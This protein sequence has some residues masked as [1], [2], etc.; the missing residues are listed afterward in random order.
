MK[1]FEA[2][3]MCYNIKSHVSKTHM[4]D[5]K[6]MT[7]TSK[8]PLPSTCNLISFTKTLVMCWV[9]QLTVKVRRKCA[10]TIYKEHRHERKTLQ[11]TLDTV[12]HCIRW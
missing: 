5:K 12:S 3:T 9:E 4:Q 10:K 6:Q 8:S 2:Y 11:E 7:K 1:T